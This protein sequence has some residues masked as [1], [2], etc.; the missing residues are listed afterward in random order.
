MVIATAQH[1]VDLP[2]QKRDL[3]AR[4]Q[5]VG[6]G[7][8]QIGHEDDFCRSGGIGRQ[9]AKSARFNQAG[10]GRGAACHHMVAVQKHFGLVIGDKA[11]AIGQQC[12]RKGGF[13]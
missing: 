10:Q 3:A 8:G 11:C 13:S 9:E 1:K 7:C 5:A 2:S 12:Q 4:R 6:F